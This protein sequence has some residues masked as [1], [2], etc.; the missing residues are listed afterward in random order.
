VCVLQGNFMAQRSALCVAATQGRTT[1]CLSPTQKQ[2]HANTRRLHAGQA[3][4]GVAL[5]VALVGTATDVEE[6]AHA[7][8]RAP[9]VRGDPVR[10]AIRARAPAKNLHGEAACVRAY[11]CVCEEREIVC[12]CVCVCV[13]VRAC[14]CV[15]VSHLNGPG[16]HDGLLHCD[17]ALQL[18]G[19]VGFGAAGSVCVR[20]AEARKHCREARRAQERRTGTD[21]N[22][23]THTHTHTHTDTDTD[24]D[25]DTH[26]RTHTHT[27]THTH[28]D[29]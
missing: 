7:P 1:G 22:E 18:D 21:R 9:A 11:V 26:T 20:V 16:C 8:L 2:E 10:D 17:D 6:A 15:H 12:V 4:D 19:G 13:C 29:L 27:H 24:T 28:T 25:T 5:N 14:F 3:G 23:H